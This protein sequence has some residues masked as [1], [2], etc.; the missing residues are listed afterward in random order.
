MSKSLKSGT[1]SLHKETLRSLA[2]SD[3]A[4][5]VGGVESSSDPASAPT[6]SCVPNT[7]VIVSALKKTCLCTNGG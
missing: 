2:P 6:A 4:R 1:L 3:L 5:A 7:T